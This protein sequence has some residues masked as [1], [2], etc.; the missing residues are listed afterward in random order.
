M[1]AGQESCPF[2]GLVHLPKS[3]SVVTHA[4]KMSNQNCFCEMSVSRVIFCPARAN[5]FLV[6]LS[7]ASSQNDISSTQLAEFQLPFLFIYSIM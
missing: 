6:Q 2:D 7:L 4:C 1:C 3:M 5:S